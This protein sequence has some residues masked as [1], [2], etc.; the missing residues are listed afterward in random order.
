MTNTIFIV[1]FTI[2]S[3]IAGPT[4]K[5]VTELMARGA[6]E[7]D[8]GVRHAAGVPPGQPVALPG[9]PKQAA[10]T[11]VLADA[12]A[13]K[14]RTGPVAATPAVLPRPGVQPAV[15]DADA[16]LNAEKRNAGNEALPSPILLAL[17][18]DTPNRRPDGTV[19][20]PIAIQHLI[21]LRT[22][23]TKVGQFSTAV[24][25]PGR[26]ATSRDVGALIQATQLG[27]ME[28][29]GGPLPNVGMRVQKG[30]LLAYLLPIIDAS[31]AAELNAK[32][33]ELK[34]LVD[35]GEQRIA[36]L[37]EVLL[38]RYR[39][40]K[41]DAVQAEIDSDRR[42]LGIYQALLTDRAEIRAHTSGVVSQVNF[43]E[44][45]IV[46]PQAKL[47][48][49][50]DPTRLTVEAASFEPS[51]GD[52]IDEAKALTVDGT[53]LPLKFAGGGL[54]LQNQAVPLQFGISAP[55]PDVQIGRPVTVVVT[56][57]SVRT[58]GIRLPA[59]AL[60]HSTSGESVVWEKLSAETFTTRPVAAQPLDGDTIVIT[61]GLAANMRIVTANS[62]ILMQVR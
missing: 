37:R 40:S 29:A 51:L 28:S 9:A 1:L 2:A 22:E 8:T 56:R 23:I 47:F 6:I 19:F 54:I 13:I 34:G 14:S 55:V 41:I 26:I 18:S 39:Q 30:Q 45:Q 21:G 60:L 27:V 24:Q 11:S 32:I 50:V 42:Q 46:E 33:A 4:S 57:R 17:A 53:V 12:L 16:E 59:S 48:E 36:R 7:Q 44:G 5:V 10:S 62:A 20:L 15:A 25:I 43:V 58:N 3:M 38:I 61:S 52:D 35:M 31:R 49:I